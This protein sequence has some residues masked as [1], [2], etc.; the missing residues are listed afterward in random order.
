MEGCHRDLARLGERH[1]V[2]HREL[3]FGVGR[4]GKHFGF[5]ALTVILQLDLL[6]GR[7]VG[8]RDGHGLAQVE[9]AALDGHLSEFG[10]NDRRRGRSVDPPCVRQ[11]LG[12]R[13]LRQ[14]PFGHQSLGLHDRI[15]LLD[16]RG[17][18]HRERFGALR[19]EGQRL[20]APLYLRHEV[21]VA[22]RQLQFVA[23]DRIRTLGLRGQ[24]IETRN[25]QQERGF[26]RHVDGLGAPL[27]HDGHLGVRPCMAAGR[28]AE[29][30][31][32]TLV[33]DLRKIGGFDRRTAEADAG[34]LPE[35]A[36]RN[37]N[38]GTDGT[39]GG[40]EARHKS[41]GHRNGHEIIIRKYGL[42][43]QIV[44]PQL[45]GIGQIVLGIVERRNPEF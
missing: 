44:S 2:G 24:S 34:Y 41:I 45:D 11:N 20:V 31:E 38:L 28:H 39:L 10:H 27:G 12:L 43:V 22:T 6:H 1:A 3:Q 5:D 42:L 23:D 14:S 7:Q 32:S 33:V 26:A 16:G 15:G 36:A 21:E 9:L 40:S 17:E 18:T 30:H 4:T 8:A 25:M 13:R 35:V 37:G 19:N 29:L